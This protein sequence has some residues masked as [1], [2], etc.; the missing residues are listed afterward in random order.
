MDFSTVIRKQKS[1]DNWRQLKQVDQYGGRHITVKNQTCLNFCSNDYLGLNQHPEIN[2]ALQQGVEKFG[3]CSTGSPLLS[4]YHYAHK[5]LE[6]KICSWLNMPACLLFSSG[7]AA[8]LGV[9]Q[10]FLKQDS[11]LFVD[12]LSHASIMDA[13]IHAKGSYSRFQHNN[14]SHLQQLLQNKNSDQKQ[15]LIVTEGVFSMD[16]DRADLKKLK[17]IVNSCAGTLYIDDAHALGVIG[18]HGEGSS[19][20]LDNHIVMGTFGKALGCSGAFI[21]CDEATKDFLVN[22]C[23]HYIYS[24]SISPAIAWATITAIDLVQK[25]HWRR[26]KIH[27][28]S[29][30]FREHLSDQIQLIPSQSSIHAIVVGANNNTVEL[31][32]K[33]QKSGILTSTIR[34]PTV[35]VNSSRLRITLCAFHEPEDVIQLAQ[36][37]NAMMG[38]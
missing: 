29:E 23:R 32:E 19:Q 5:A 34:P 7:F 4:G 20:F 14:C 8:N 12:K 2:K 17:P 35:A 36:T 3:L 37:L 31:G 28:L 16:G 38:D 6:D 33:L 26:D 18:D 13:I 10:A 1:Q 15:N 21:A 30:L 11:Y 27:T 25:D 24:T 22:F 9:L